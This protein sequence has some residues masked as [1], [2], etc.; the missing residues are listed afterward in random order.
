MP[1][2]CAKYSTSWYSQR[3]HSAGASCAAATRARHCPDLYSSAEGSAPAPIGAGALVALRT[4]VVA[5]VVVGRI[6]AEGGDAVGAAD[7]LGLVGAWWV[8]RVLEAQ[9]GEVQRGP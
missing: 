9:E 7:L 4:G 2:G 5:D 6:H 3:R 8:A 1:T